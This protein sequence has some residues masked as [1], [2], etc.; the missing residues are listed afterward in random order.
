MAAF[1]ERFT[2]NRAGLMHYGFTPVRLEGAV[3][4]LVHHPFRR[5]A[6]FRTPLRGTMSGIV[7]SFHPNG[8]VAA[9]PEAGARSRDMQPR[10]AWRDFQGVAVVVYQ[11]R[12]ARPLVLH[13]TQRGQPNAMPLRRGSGRALFDLHAPQR[14]FII[15]SRI[16]AN[17]TG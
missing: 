3:S 11:T 13:A 17:G 4:E 16:A 5:G 9:V 2:E 12:C 14:R 6:A 1:G 8:V 10:V 15:A 7:A